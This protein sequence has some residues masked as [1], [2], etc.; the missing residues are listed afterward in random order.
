MSPVRGSLLSPMKRRPWHQERSKDGKQ[1][2]SQREIA[3][4]PAGAL[5]LPVK[6]MPDYKM[7]LPLRGRPWQSLDLSVELLDRLA[8]W[9]D[10]LDANFDANNGWKSAQ[11]RSNWAE[12]G[13]AIVLDL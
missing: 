2:R 8:D 12:Q 11:A 7:E 4:M 13:A 1:N 3:K 5:S 9:Q 6:L 10:E